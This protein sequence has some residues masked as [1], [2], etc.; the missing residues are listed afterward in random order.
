[1]DTTTHLMQIEE[2]RSTLTRLRQNPKTQRKFPR[3]LWDSI[4]Q[5]TK[6]CPIEELCRQLHINPVYLKDKIRDS[7]GQALEFREISMPG[8]QPVSETVTIELSTS[9]G[10]KARIQ[11]PI[12]CINNLYKLFEG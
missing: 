3:E 5:L 6:I 4:I 10:L 8:W 7:K 12:A 11:G 2:I 9:S 1:M